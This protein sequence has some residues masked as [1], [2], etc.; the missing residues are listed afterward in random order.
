MRELVNHILA[1]ADARGIKITNLQLQ[2]ILYFSVIEAL[3][4][5]ILSTDE[6]EEIYNEPFL[7][8]RYG[9]VVES[10]YE[11]YKKYGSTSILEDGILSIEYNDLNDFIETQLRRPAFDLVDESHTHSK[12]YENESKIKYGRSEIE[13]TIEDLM[14]EAI[15]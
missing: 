13:Y 15:I 12:W 11:E 14:L 3:R 2:K 9:P 8:W 1:V 10:I 5:N 4:R 7:V 6:L